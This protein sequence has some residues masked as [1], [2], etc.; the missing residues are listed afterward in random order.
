MTSKIPN[1]DDLASALSEQRLFSAKFFDSEELT[2]QQKQEMLKTFVLS[3]HAEVTGI[4]EAV[5]YKDHRKQQHP[6]D[7]Q[8]IL[9]KS[10]DAYRYV[11]AILNL[12]N[13]DADTFA[14]ALEQKDDYLH[15]RHRLLAKQMLP[16]Q[17]VVLFDLDDVIAEFR[18]SFCDFATR[19]IGTFV[20]PKSDEYY[21]LRTFKQQGADAEKVFRNFIDSHGFL[22]LGVN[23]TYSRL[24]EELRNEGRWIQV[25]TARP[26]D[27]LTCFYDTYSWLSRL[28]IEVDGV[29]FTPEKF[30]WVS[31][32]PFYDK[33]EIIAVDD[34]AKHAAEYAKHGIRVVVPQQSYNGE[35][36]GLDN[37]VYVESGFDPYVAIQMAGI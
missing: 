7:V 17:K 37:V 27:N 8:K 6:V 28:G 21:N 31:E 9:Y 35:V 10:V 5:N 29:T 13:I 2:L 3:L 22:G 12:W 32:Q 23:K 15:F 30:R 4:V 25:V 26:I 16:G 36:A 20:D 34:S 1:W 19:Q 18:T 11:L 24:L 14:S 33:H